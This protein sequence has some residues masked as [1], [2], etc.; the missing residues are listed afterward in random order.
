M[1]FQGILSS[2]ESHLYPDAGKRTCPVPLSG[3]QYS[4]EAGWRRAS[5]SVSPCRRVKENKSELAHLLVA[6]FW[7]LFIWGARG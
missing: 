2:P 3:A 7:L 4:A 1:A 6:A 5:L